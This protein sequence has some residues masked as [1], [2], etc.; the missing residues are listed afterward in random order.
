MGVFINPIS[1]IVLIVSDC[2]RTYGQGNRPH[3]RV[4]F[5]VPKTPLYT[6]GGGGV[7]NFNPIFIFQ[8]APVSLG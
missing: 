2:A 7:L 5:N 4:T 3:L 6:Q 1:S 8:Y